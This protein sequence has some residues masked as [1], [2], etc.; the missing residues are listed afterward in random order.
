MVFANIF[1]DSLDVAF[2]G[3]VFAVGSDIGSLFS[4]S[5]L[6]VSVFGPGNVL[7]GTAPAFAPISGNGFFGVESTTTA[8]TR[9]NFNSPT[10]QAEG[11]TNVAFGTGRA[12]VPE[13]A[14]LAL[15]GLGL[16]GLGFSRRR[17]SN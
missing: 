4:A 8:I 3:G 17:K 13:P 12:A 15:L 6:T 16:A 2:P 10:N 11:V 14:T 7:L 1:S 5:T 9:I